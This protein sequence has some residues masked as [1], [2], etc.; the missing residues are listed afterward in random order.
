V[1]LSMIEQA[2]DVHPIIAH[3]LCLAWRGCPRTAAEG[4]ANLQAPVPAVLPLDPPDDA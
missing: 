3:S 4:R 1:P 2:E